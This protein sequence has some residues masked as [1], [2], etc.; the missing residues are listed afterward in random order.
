MTTPT[1]DRTMPG[2]RLLL[3]ISVLG[4]V[5]SIFMLGL[6]E[7]WRAA[8]IANP[9]V[10][11]LIAIA[12][13][14]VIFVFLPWFER[15]L[16]TIFLPVS[17]SLYLICQSLLS[18]L[19]HNW[20]MVRYDMVDFGPFTVLEPGVLLII[21]ALLIAWQYGWI[22]A[23]AASAV[24]GTL[25]LLVGL[26]LRTPTDT[27]L[28]PIL[29]PDMLYFLPLLV[30]YLGILLRRQ[31]RRVQ[32]ADTHWRSY[33]ATAELLAAERER[34]RVAESLQT[35]LLPPLT[36]LDHQLH[37]L[38]SALPAG[39]ADQLK[40]VRRQAQRMMFTTDEMIEDL[41]AAP[42]REMGLVEALQTRAEMVAER[43]GLEVDVQATELPNTI[44]EHQEM[45]LYHVADQVLNA[46]TQHEQVGCVKL[47]LA[48]ID[49]FV[50]LTIHDDGQA[51][52]A[53]Q[54]H[55]AT[56]QAC[57]NLIGGQFCTH[58]RE[59]GGNTVAVWLPCGQNPDQ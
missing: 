32:E 31:Q 36:T 6:T 38:V 20:Q 35:A 18:G 30:A 23:L 33:A 58:G 14:P 5:A 17:L 27:A 29:R 1:S 53:D 25:H 11:W 28:P 44:T 24:T 2:V 50:A 52:E 34:Q 8:Q 13:L 26:A 15:R 9:Q 46:V 51:N 7:H 54:K 3:R 19:L 48:V 4:P 59:D 45:V 56:L 12:L 49:N 39:I 40:A 42:L 43:H 21:P 37:G 22:G 47:H 41:Q 10:L 55:L 16:A 57:T